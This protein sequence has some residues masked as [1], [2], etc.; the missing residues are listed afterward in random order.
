M[1]RRGVHRLECGCGEAIYATVPTLERYV[2]RYRLLPVCPCGGSYEPDNPE[3]ALLLGCP[4][5]VLAEF[6]ERCA[7]AVRGQNGNRDNPNL[8]HPATVA[9][10]G[11]SRRPGMLQ[12]RRERALERRL[13]ALK[14]ATD[15]IPF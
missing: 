7:E 1:T 6:Q 15:P 9:L 5:A 10:E 14:P 4:C 13:A 12:E 2:K 11:T 8:R 3:L